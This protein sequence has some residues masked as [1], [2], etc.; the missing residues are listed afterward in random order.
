MVSEDSPS[1]HADHVLDELF[2]L[3]V[4]SLESRISRIESELKERMRLQDQTVSEIGTHKRSLKGALFRLRY[5]PEMARGPLRNQLLG[6]ETLRWTELRSAL[7]DTSDLNESLQK[8]REELNT[9]I[10]KRSLIMYGID[11]T[12]LDS[13]TGSRDSND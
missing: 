4:K 6:V 12:V 5:A 9:A 3:P 2:R 8:T 13:E 10:R 11:D 1:K 7:K